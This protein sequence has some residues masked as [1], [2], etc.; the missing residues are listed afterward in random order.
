MSNILYV[1][2]GFLSSQDKANITIELIEQLKKLDPSKEIL[3]IN[4]YNNSWGLEKQVNYYSEYLD[5]FLVGYPPK[6]VLENEQYDKP[7][8]YFEIEQGILENWMPLEG[9]SDHVANVYNSFIFSLKEAKKLNYD[10]VFRIEYDMLFDEEEF[11]LILNDLDKFENEDFLIYGKRQEGNWSKSY[12]SLIDLHFC[13]YSSKILKNFDYVKNDKEFW[14]LCSKINYTGK[15]SEYIMS[16]SS[17]FNINNCVGIIYDGITRNKF[18]NSQFDR[19]S[20]SGEWTDKWKDIPKI[21]KLDVD[22]GHKLDPSK[23]V[24]FYLN[25]DYEFAEVEVV[26]TNNY[27]KKEN[28]KI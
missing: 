13:G 11:K 28:S 23:V 5:G 21:C 3:L 18:P 22:N 19:I 10:K 12:Q 14:E 7:Y 2:D 1:I 17:N 24:I 20:S 6:E 26:G 25:K 9:V 16:M 4:K 8:V 27:Y 15:W